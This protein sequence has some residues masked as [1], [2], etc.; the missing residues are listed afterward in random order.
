MTS[1][2]ANCSRVTPSVFG[3]IGRL[4]VRLTWRPSSDVRADARYDSNLNSA[5]ASFY[6][7]PENLA[8][9]IGY[10]AIAT[11]DDGPASLLGGVD[12]VGNRFN[13]SISHAGYGQDF[14]SISDQQVLE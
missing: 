8:G 13:A 1:M 4:T 14:G 2:P 9:S 12:Y 7:I 3:P 10:S 5:S 6:K 11:Y